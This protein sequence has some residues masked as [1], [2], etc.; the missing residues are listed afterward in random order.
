MTFR[1]SIIVKV[2]LTFIGLVFALGM[3]FISWLEMVQSHTVD[4]AWAFIGLS[5]VG[6]GAIMFSLSGPDDITFDLE[7]K[8]YHRVWGWPFFAKTRTGTWNDFWGV[9]VGKGHGNHRYFCTGVMWR[10]GA[11]MRI[12]VFSDQD[13]AEQLAMLLMRRLELERV[14]PPRSLR[15]QA[16]PRF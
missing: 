1:K 8:T 6:V 5:G 2:G 11:H 15:P 9:F 7:R 10:D 16:Q 13:A 3:P 4:F 12:G 14:M